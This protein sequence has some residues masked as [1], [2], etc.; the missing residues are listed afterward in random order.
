[1]LIL[2]WILA[3]WFVIGAI[4][5]SFSS[6]A[7]PSTPNFVLL[8]IMW[9]MVLADIIG[10]VLVKRHR[11]KTGYYEK[12]QQRFVNK[13]GAAGER[14]VARYLKQRMKDGEALYNDIVIPNGNNNTAQ[15]DHIYVSVHGVFV[16]E[17]KN[18]TGK[19]YGSEND[20]QWVE[21]YNYGRE[22]FHF[23]NP[24]AQNATH[25]I[26]VKKL[27]RDTIDVPIVS[28]VIFVDGGISSVNA[29]VYYLDNVKDLFNQYKDVNLSHDDI[30]EITD[31]LDAYKAIT[32]KAN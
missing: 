7:N 19:I 3:I 22:K 1:M 32:P 18:Y 14:K 28:V 20:N 6:I 26:A 31:V 5:A 4:G 30:A 16:I 17:T 23:Y 25:V 9:G 15:I 8:G 11:E 29:D 13:Q 21:C 12:R 27:L 2:L 10:I 24:V